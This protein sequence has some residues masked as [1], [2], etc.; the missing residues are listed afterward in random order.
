[1]EPDDA[2]DVLTTKDVLLADI[3]ANPDDDVP[4]LIYA[5]YIDDAEPERAEFIRL[6]I[7]IAGLLSCPRSSPLRKRQ[8]QIL[9]KKNA[10][11]WFNVFPSEK[12]FEVRNGNYLWYYA[13]PHKK[14]IIR[15]GFVNEIVCTSA[16]LL[17]N[18]GSIFVRHPVERVRLSDDPLSFQL[19][20][21]SGWSLEL[22]DEVHPSEWWLCRERKR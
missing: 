5:D 1:M 16:E 9:R 3:L 11:A 15:R 17:E 7:K 10:K 8:Q 6:Q 20:I 2:D 4:R 14:A 12:G 22:P 21:S 19:I 13:I 18:D